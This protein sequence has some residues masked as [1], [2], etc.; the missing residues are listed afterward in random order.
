MSD[1]R[2]HFPLNVLDVETAWFTS[3]PET[4]DSERFAWPWHLLVREQFGEGE[5][6]VLIAKLE[7]E[8]HGKVAEPAAPYEGSKMTQMRL[9]D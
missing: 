6:R 2:E 5:C 7:A 1:W 8:G 3:T 4:T 9:F